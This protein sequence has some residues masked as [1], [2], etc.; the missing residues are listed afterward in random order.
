MC[1]CV[2]V[3]SNFPTSGSNP[4]FASQ[5]TA[6]LAVTTPFVAEAVSCQ[7]A[8]HTKLYSDLLQTVKIRPHKRERKK[9]IYIYSDLL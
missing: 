2:C 8:K 7:Q 9:N 4:I 5:D 3:C 1:V 6:T